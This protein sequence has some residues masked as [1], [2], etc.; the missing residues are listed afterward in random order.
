MKALSYVRDLTNE[1][2][3]K[4]LTEYGFVD[5]E[6]ILIHSL[7]YRFKSSGH[8]ELSCDIST[9]SDGLI[10]LS[11]TTTDS[12]LID[13]WNEDE[14]YFE[15]ENNGHWFESNEHVMSTAFEYI[16]KDTRNTD[17]LAEYLS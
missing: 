12:M 14:C 7:N 16:I 9:M 10:T 4:I 3:E 1:S 13:D 15:Q 5:Q 8:W 6:C 17:L 11:V 2:I